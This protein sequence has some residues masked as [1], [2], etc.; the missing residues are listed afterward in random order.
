[1]P[2]LISY[3]KHINALVTREL[4][5]PQAA[6]GQRLGE[7][8]ATLGDITYV[9]LPGGATLP[10]NQPAE[11]AASIQTVTPGAALLDAIAAASP[12][13]RVIRAAVAARIAERYSP[14]DEIKLL[15]HARSAD[16]DAYNTYAEECRAWGREQ[17][18][19]LLPPPGVAEANAL[20]MAQIQALESRELLPRPVRDMVKKSVAADAAALGYTLNQVYALA[21]AM[22][23]SAPEAAKGWKKFKDFDDQ[24]QALKEQLQ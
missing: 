11:I 5:L 9:S 24:I 23:D 15:R 8:I 3:R 22:G 19:T 13:V 12:Q 18:A 14:A 1:M 4:D 7:E 21:V 17:K 16:Y 6:A 10:A 20:I 2:S